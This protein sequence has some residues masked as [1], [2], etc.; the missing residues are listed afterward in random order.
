MNATVYTT[1]KNRLELLLNQR[2][3]E[4]TRPKADLIHQNIYADTLTELARTQT[5][6]WWRPL[7]H[8]WAKYESGLLEARAGHLHLAEQ[9]FQEAGEFKRN[10]PEQHYLP[11][12]AEVSALPAV[13]Y[14]HYKQ[15]YFAQAENELLASLDND[16]VLLEQGYFILEYHRIQQLHNLARSC[17]FQKRMQDG[18]RLIGLALRYML[19]GQV[20]P[21]SYGWSE[22]YLQQAPWQLRSDMLWQLSAE[23][24][25]VLL[26]YRAEE[27]VLFSEAFG[28]LTFWEPHTPDDEVLLEWFTLKE[29]LAQVPSDEA[30]LRA[31]RFLDQQPAAFDVYKLSLL[32]SVVEVLQQYRYYTPEVH[33]ILTT[34]V[35]TLQ[36]SPRNRQSCQLYLDSLIENPELLET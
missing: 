5:G 6:T 21:L 24:A 11:E 2:A 13:A 30:V 17:F 16:A 25:G 8:L 26:H 9:Y 3:P 22:G 23:T 19:Y 28:H 18:A 10:F 27:K 4:S 35:G 15:G 12:L 31:V 29:L 34:L 1:I 7:N 20:P 36:I 14:L 32:M 33:R